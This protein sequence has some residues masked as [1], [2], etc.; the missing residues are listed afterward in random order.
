M[1][2]ST[3]TKTGSAMSAP[4][5]GRA[6][7][8]ICRVREG[9]D[10]ADMFPADF[11]EKFRVCK[12]CQGSVAPLADTSTITLNVMTI[13][14]LCVCP[15]PVNGAV[16]EEKTICREKSPS[17][18]RVILSASFSIIHSSTHSMWKTHHIVHR[19]STPTD[20]N[21][22]ALPPRRALRCLMLIGDAARHGRSYTIGTEDEGTA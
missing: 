14:S 3:R 13:T 7:V 19:Q 5:A 12:G 10:A 2:E 6:R 4:S 8:R 18:I 20:M 21:E 9:V 22:G 17:D 1:A 15:Q 16:D 11:R